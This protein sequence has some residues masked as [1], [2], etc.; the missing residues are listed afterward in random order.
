MWVVLLGLATGEEVNRV[1][2]DVYLLAY[3]ESIFSSNL[4]EPVSMCLSSNR[5]W[6]YRG[7]TE[8]LVRDLLEVLEYPHHWWNSDKRYNWVHVNPAAKLVNSPNRCDVHTQPRKPPR[9]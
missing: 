6:L 3:G 7:L 4:K 2:N 5:G 1:V 8:I 9:T